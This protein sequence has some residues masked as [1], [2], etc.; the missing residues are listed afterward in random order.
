MNRCS[1]RMWKTG[2]KEKSTRINALVRTT[3]FTPLNFLRLKAYM[4]HTVVWENTIQ[5]YSLQLQNDIKSADMYY[6]HTFIKIL[7]WQLLPCYNEHQR[8]QPSKYYV[9]LHVLLAEQN[10]YIPSQGQN[11]FEQI[12][13]KSNIKYFQNAINGF[14]WMLLT[15]KCYTHE[16][17]LWEYSRN[18][19]W[20][21]LLKP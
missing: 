19:N 18:T 14:E 9:P 16:K 13:I 21:I 1:K 5:N 20:T 2:I 8:Q 4:D 3:P 11:N 10:R 6:S 7:R 15:V 17:K 12:V